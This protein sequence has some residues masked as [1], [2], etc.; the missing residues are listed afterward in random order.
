VKK[1]EAKTAGNPEEKR[2]ERE[3][4]KR[5]IMRVVLRLMYPKLRHRERKKKPPTLHVRHL[6]DFVSH[7]NILGGRK[8]NMFEKRTKMIEKQTK[9]HFTI[10]ISLIYITLQQNKK[11][12]SNG[13]RTGHGLFFS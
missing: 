10:N 9:V 6:Y 1:Q 3:R 8:P 2:K 5:E 7:S 4:E 13:R 12:T 11:S